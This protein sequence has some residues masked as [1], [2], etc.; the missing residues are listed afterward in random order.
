MP[1]EEWSPSP[2]FS[3]RE[4]RKIIAIVD[5]ITAGSGNGALSWLSNPQSQ[6][7]AHY[8]VFKTGR[9]IQLV[10]EGD[11]AWHA[12]SVNKPNWSLYDGTN[13]NLYCVTPD[14]RILLSNMQWVKASELSVG[15]RI[16]GFDEEP[17]K[18]EGAINGRRY[19]HDACVTALKTKKADVYEIEM[20]DG[21]TLQSTGEHKWLYH[22]GV[23]HGAKWIRTDQMESFLMSYKNKNGLSLPRYFNVAEAKKTYETGFLS[24]AFDGEGNFGFKKGGCLQLC[25][26]QKDN[27]MLSRVKEYLEGCNFSY[28]ITI[29]KDETCTLYLTGGKSEVFRFLHETNP[30]RLI[31]RFTSKILEQLTTYPLGLVRVLSIRLLG[32]R[33]I[34]A[35]SSSTQTYIA[36]GFGS[37]NTIGIEHEGQSGESLTEPQYQSSL[38]LHKELTLKYGIPIDADNIIGHYRIDSVNRPNCPGSGFPWDRLFKDLKGDEVLADNPTLILG[39]KGSEVARLQNLLNARGANIIADGDFGP[40]TK[41]AVINFQAANG[42]LVDGVVGSQTWARLFVPIP[43]APVTPTVMYRVIMDG[44]QIMAIASHDKA[45]SEVKKAVD[46]GTAMKGIVQRNDGTNVFEYVKPVVVPVV[47]NKEKLAID[48]MQQAIKILE[49]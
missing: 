13:P 15:T 24:A 22:A 46:E 10:K 18:T 5:H 6:A 20:E 36:E 43:V 39:S 33:E 31:A 29:A 1:I 17:I 9:I 47:P 28:G 37:H 16:V 8:L 26:T 14:T 41:K 40:A 21:T 30:P 32:E 44:V 19:L 2:N 3:S 38:F 12:G 42:L 25:F 45:I 49:G 23:G 27:A 35:F 34:V 4:G 11:K 7:S 48:H